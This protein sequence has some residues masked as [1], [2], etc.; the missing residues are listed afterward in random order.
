MR[1][2]VQAY[3]SAART[4]SPTDVTIDVPAWAKRVQVYIDATAIV[5]T[6]SVVFNIR[7]TMPSGTNISLL[8]SA[9]VTAVSQTAL[10]IGPG[11]V[12]VANLAAQKLLPQSL[13]ID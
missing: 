9:A 13:V 11:V 5:T 12:A 8:A 2:V 1:S 6:P 10:V 7:G 4:A 3:A